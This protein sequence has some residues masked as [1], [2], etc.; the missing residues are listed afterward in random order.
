LKI[1]EARLPAFLDTN[2]WNP[3]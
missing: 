3:Q 1:A 2:T